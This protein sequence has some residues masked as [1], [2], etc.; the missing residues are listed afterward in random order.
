[1][2]RELPYVIAACILAAITVY[3]F[4]PLASSQPFGYDESDYMWAG[5]QGVLANYTD[6]HGLSIVEFITR[7]LDL[8]RNPEKRAE[9][10]RFIRDSGDI[11]AYRHYHGPLYAYWL[12]VLS[13]LGITREEVF[14]GAGLVIHIATAFTILIGMWKVFPQLPRIAGLAGCALFL[15]NRTALT[16]AGTITQHGLFTFWVI[17]VLFAAS[18]FFRRY[19]DRWLYATV[20]LLAA[21]AATVETAAVLGASLVVA[22]LVDYR[23]A[24]ARWQ[25]VASIRRTAAKA[26]G[27][28]LLTVL[29]L[30]PKGILHAAILKGF[31]QQGY[32]AVARKS[33][34]PVSP[35]GLWQ[36]LFVASPGE[37]AILLC[38]LI[39]AAAMWRGSQHRSEMLPWLVYVFMFLLVT[40]KVTLPYTYYFAPLT[41]AAVVVA[42]TA[43]GMVWQRSRLYIRAALSVVMIAAMFATAAEWARVS[44]EVRDADSFLRALLR[45]VRSGGIEPGRTF[46]VPFYAVPILHYYN[47][48]IATAGV[49]Y[50][51]PVPEIVTELRSP[52]TASTMIC[53]GPM[54][55]AIERVGGELIESRTLLHPQGAMGRP[56]YVL[57]V[58]KR[59]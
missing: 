40:L 18:M 23:R 30:W 53:D 41:A 2:N 7:G 33:F 29:V 13:G 50:G 44:R 55:D 58:R 47:P 25:S 51:Y 22:L 36:S 28:F 27:V 9:F 14:R 17:A 1:M 16:A 38:G 4:F 3:V 43:F 37:F 8:Y 46:Y 59:S 45:Y 32:M 39:A 31:L 6:R 48:E 20:A 57:H 42:A 21:G 11:G 54:C 26:A 10:S 19:D 35:L 52:A 49:D 5:K 12:A 15:F 34:S 56:W 24:R